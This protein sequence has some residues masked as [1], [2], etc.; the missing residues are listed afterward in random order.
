MFHDL[1][2]RRGAVLA[3]VALVA[4]VVAVV[5]VAPK[6]QALTAV[7]TEA[8]YRS[9]LDAC[10]SLSA[11][12]ECVIDIVAEMDMTSTGGMPVYEGDADLTITSS[13]GQGAL[14]VNRT[15]NIRFLTFQPSTS[16]ATLTIDGVILV[17]FGSD[18]VGTGGAVYAVDG[19]VSVIDSQFAYN[20]ASAHGGAIAVV[21]GD[22][23][24]TDSTF[25]LNHAPDYGAAIY[26]YGPSDDITVHG[27]LFYGNEGWDL[28]G[29]IHGWSGAT[30]VSHTT[31]WTN[32]ATNSG[33]AISTVDGDVTLDHVTM[34]RNSAD[35]GSQVYL[36]NSAT[37]TMR[38]S[39]IN[40]SEELDD[41][42]ETTGAV[43]VTSQGYNV[44]S[45]V[46]CVDAL[47]GSDVVTGESLAFLMDSPLDE[48]D[49]FPVPHPDSMLRDLIPAAQCTA[50]T[51]QRGLARPQGSGCEPG[52]VEVGPSPFSD[53]P[54]THPFAPHVLWLANSGITG[55]YEDGT[56]KPSAPVSRMA[57]AAFLFRLLG[58]EEAT[59]PT[60]PTFSDVPVSHP[61][62]E[63]IEWLVDLGV[64]TGYEDGTFRPSSPVSRQATAAF[65]Y[66]LSGDD[67][68]SPD[69][70]EFSDVPP[71]H[72][73][74]TEIDW[75]VDAGVTTGYSDGTFR[76][77]AVVT[78]QAMAA[79]LV[80]VQDTFR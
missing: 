66:R 31:F 12:E 62:Y 69:A 5:P 56:F 53:V 40:T 7:T 25:L 60:T 23:S 35:D 1:S 34:H 79:F 72:P 8:Q 67:D 75:L 76:P 77:S 45:T 55:G 13:T 57:M 59:P 6:A 50:V 52:A 46:G 58:P 42:C 17:G 70:Q 43:A 15:H 10:E 18:S 21:G 9:A 26:S 20:Q 47:A 19:N 48:P 63:E 22:L 37:L 32:S 80:R 39:V 24:V 51:D 71:S 78:R 16:T 28:G 11:G 27:S 3:L 2:V 68:H 64:T 4:A 30:S 54:M 36:G 61:F 33:G 14:Q 65:L 44:M 74:Y 29:A 38:A 49:T 73:F 41:W